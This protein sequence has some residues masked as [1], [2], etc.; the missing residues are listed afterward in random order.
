MALGS[1]K[2]QQLDLSHCIQLGPISYHTGEEHSTTKRTHPESVLDSHGSGSSYTA[3]SGFQHITHD[4]KNPDEQK[5]NHTKKVLWI[6]TTLHFHFQLPEYKHV[7]FTTKHGSTSQKQL[8]NST[9]PKLKAQQFIS[10]NKIKKRNE[11]LERFHILE[12]STQG[13]RR[14]GWRREEG[15]VEASR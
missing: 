13:E 8:S 4:L 1:I 10:P 3:T 7:I 11:N 12:H 15:Q 5:S 6:K 2:T 9:K 14:A